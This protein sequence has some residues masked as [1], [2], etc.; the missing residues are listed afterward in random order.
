M[1]D[2]TRPPANIQVPLELV[3]E[4]LT[5]KLGIANQTI[6]ILEAANDVLQQQLQH[7]QGLLP[8]NIEP[9]G[10]DVHIHANGDGHAHP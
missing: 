9:L 3:C 6:A 1:S 8:G 4:K 7:L 2:T 5:Q 10:G